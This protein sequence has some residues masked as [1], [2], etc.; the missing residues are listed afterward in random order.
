MAHHDRERRASPHA[1]SA[2][3]TPLVGRRGATWFPSRALQ[4]AD[5]P[6]CFP[7]SHPPRWSHATRLPGSTCFCDSTPGLSQPASFS[8]KR[9]SF[10]YR[11]AIFQGCCRRLS[12]KK[13]QIRSAPLNEVIGACPPR[14]VRVPGQ[15]CPPA[16]STM[17]SV[18]A[19]EGVAW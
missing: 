8:P 17:N 15:P 9:G 3:R 14:R 4:T 1:V 19:P 10:L 18:A 12:W 11:R 16:E 2:N 7:A 13:S 5:S 6:L